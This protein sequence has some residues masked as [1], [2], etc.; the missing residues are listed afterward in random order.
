VISLSLHA[1]ILS[2]HIVEES[3][4]IS[5]SISVKMDEEDVLF[6]EICSAEHEDMSDEEDKVKSWKLYSKE[7]L[8][9]SIMKYYYVGCRGKNINSANKMFLPGHQPPHTTIICTFKKSS[10]EVMKDR[11][12]SISHAKTELELFN[13]KKEEN[14]S[15]QWNTV[16]Y[17]HSRLTPDK[18]KI[19]VQMCITFSAMGYGLDEMTLLVSS[20]G[21]GKMIQHTTLAITSRA[22]GELFICIG[23]HKLL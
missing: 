18:E 15:I 21:D 5:F 20:E 6:G 8:V 10:L 3:E 17:G 11:N 13:C 1:D 12:I 14:I 9:S 23:R 19:L 4:G 16:L 22:D 7:D 2:P